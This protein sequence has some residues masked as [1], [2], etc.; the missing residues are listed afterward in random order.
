[1]KKKGGQK[2][3]PELGE[4]A[5]GGN[6]GGWA[7]MGT[8]GL[9]RVGEFGCERERG[10]EKKPETSNRGATSHGGVQPTKKEEKKKAGVVHATI[11]GVLGWEKGGEKR[12]QKVPIKSRRQKGKRDA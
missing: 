6:G 7:F 2:S 9:F 12:L 4:H 11:G 10:A 5:R 8:R 1:M 3:G